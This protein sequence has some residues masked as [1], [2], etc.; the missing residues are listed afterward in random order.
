MIVEP[1]PAGAK[2]APANRTPRLPDAKS[3]RTWLDWFLGRPGKAPSTGLVLKP[4]GAGEAVEAAGRFVEAAEGTYVVRSEA[5][6][7]IDK[8]LPAGWVTLWAEGNPEPL[9]LDGKQLRADA[10]TADSLEFLL[11]SIP[12]RVVLGALQGRRE[13]WQ[14]PNVWVMAAIGLGLLT[15]AWLVGKKLGWI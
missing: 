14:L 7:W 2:E 6:F 1:I 12:A 13:G 3:R 4:S 5:R 9:T 15:T 11:G 8:P 10:L